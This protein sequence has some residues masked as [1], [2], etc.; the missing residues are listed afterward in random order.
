MRNFDLLLARIADWLE[1]D[2][3]LF[4]H[5]FCHRNLTYPFQT[6]GDSNWMGRHFFTGGMMPSEHLLRRFDRSL[7]EVDRWKWNGRHYQLT[8]EAWLKNLD[9]HRDLVLPVL[10]RT[11][12]RANGRRWL[13]RWRMFFLAVAELFGY[14]EG[15]EWFV[16]HALFARNDFRR[17]GTR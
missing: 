12:G 4:V 8:A 13:Q 6:D 9:A 3:R 1:P 15:E 17:N 10:E 16:A 14:A 5:H 11:Y 7:V 2:G